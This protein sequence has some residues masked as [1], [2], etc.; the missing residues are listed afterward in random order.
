MT[1]LDVI[2]IKKFKSLLNV[3]KYLTI[4]IL[5]YYKR[6][7]S[8]F[9]CSNHKLNIEYGR[10]FNTNREDRICFYCFLHKN[11]LILEDEYHAFLICDEFKEIREIYLYSWFTGQPSRKNL[12]SI[13]FKSKHFNNKKISLICD[14]V[15]GTN[16]ICTLQ[17]KDVLYVYMY[18]EA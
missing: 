18:C 2:F 1:L 3:E 17:S 13:F 4:D 12:H 9:R 5:P 14:K 16:L 7:L 10:Y 11:D 6:S 8:R 15:N